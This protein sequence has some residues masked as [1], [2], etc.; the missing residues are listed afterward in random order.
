[1]VPSAP[2]L[3]HLKTAYGNMLLWQVMERSNTCVS[4]TL[5]EP[6][7]LGPFAA[8][9]PFRGVITVKHKKQTDNII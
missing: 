2:T 9:G 5:K 3:S 8:A 4:K 1:M 7:L 6:P